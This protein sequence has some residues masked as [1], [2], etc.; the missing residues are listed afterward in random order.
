MY[1]IFLKVVDLVHAL[2]YIGIFIM[3]LIESTFIPIPAEITLIP[4]GYLVQSGQMNFLLV[5]LVSTAGTVAGSLINYY[6]AYFY[7][8]KLLLKYGNYFFIDEKKLQTIEFFF[9]RH[10]A[11]STF[12][13]RLLP[14]L[15]HFISFPAG[16][17]KMDLLKFCIY[18]AAGGAIWSGLLIALGYYIGRNED[19]IHQ[20]LLLINMVVIGS[21]LCLAL[22]YYMRNRG[23][24][25]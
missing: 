10:G 14:G 19:L 12:S 22:I 2:G 24:R 20:N 8:R 21:V 3:T 6:I 23:G 4:A 15:K 17:A 5:L 9:Q 13:G 11:I 25:K 7:G 18:T 16:L 1:E